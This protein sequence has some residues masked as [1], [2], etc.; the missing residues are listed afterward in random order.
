MSLT[1][2]AQRYKCDAIKPTR[3]VLLLLGL[4]VRV[5]DSCMEY[6]TCMPIYFTCMPLYLGKHLHS[7]LKTSSFIFLAKLIHASLAKENKKY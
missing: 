3:T 7:D 6:F 5:R 1:R 4:K 2:P